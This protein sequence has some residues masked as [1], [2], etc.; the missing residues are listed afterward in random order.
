MF[1][2]Q[3]FELEE[4]DS[5][6]IRRPATGATYRL[7]APRRPGFAPGEL[8][9]STLEG[10]VSDN[11][12]L[13]LGF[14]NSFPLYGDGGFSDLEC[15]ENIG[16]YDPNDKQGFPRGA[17][18]EHFIE[19]DTRLEYLI[20]FQN[21]GTDT[22]FNVAIQDT[23]SAWLDP[24]TITPGA[25]SHPYTWQLAQDGTLLFE[26]ANIMLP[27]SNVNE[28]A[29]HGFVKFGIDLRANTPLGTTIHNQAAIFFDFN[30]PIIT[31]KTMHRVNVDFLE[32][33]LA[34]TEQTHLYTG[35]VQVAPNPARQVIRFV[36]TEN[37]SSSALV[38]IYD[39]S[40]Q[41]LGTYPFQTAERQIPVDQWPAGLYFYEVRFGTG[42]T[43]GRFL[44]QR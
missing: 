7:Q 20:R 16:A 35:K 42:H 43:A 6:E 14:F 33:I 44:I 19:P 17:G 25:S 26:F 41:R 39:S 22:A 29:S 11:Q 36:K 37:Q 15:R 13:S 9:S 1:L 24:A 28:P 23:L 3:P 21:T 27:D 40:G 2:T 8:I 18:P 30:A 4:G 32:N 34:A 31:N 38:V 5:I 12:V 10:C